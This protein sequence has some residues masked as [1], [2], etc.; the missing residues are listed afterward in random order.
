MWYNM[1]YQDNLDTF[2]R[3]AWELARFGGRIHYLGYRDHAYEPNLLEASQPGKMEKIDALSKAVQALDA[4]QKS[5]P[6]SRVLPCSD[7]KTPP[8]GN[9]PTLIPGS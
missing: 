9:F 8:T 2:Y 5:L 3:E 6:D 1:W 7:G 4:F